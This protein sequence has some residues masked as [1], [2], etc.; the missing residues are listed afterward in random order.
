MI[1]KRFRKTFSA[2]LL[3]A[4]C[5]TGNAAS[6]SM[7]PGRISHY[8]LL[9][10]TIL[11]F[12]I[13]YN[14]TDQPTLGGGFDIFFPSSVLR[15]TAFSLEAVGDPE[16]MRLPDFGDGVLTGTAFGD[17]GGID[18][19]GLLGQVQFEAIGVQFGGELITM[20]DNIA[21]PGPFVD[22]QTFEIMTVDYNGVDIIPVPAAL[23]LLSSGVGML[24]LTRRKAR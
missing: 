15:V 8:D 9:P 23:W 22:F 12:D 6:I 24:M 7:D 2:L 5:A 3:A 13:L 1:I 20:A 14:F 18:D 10:G 11:S 21:P 19:S 4:A 16:F 17:F